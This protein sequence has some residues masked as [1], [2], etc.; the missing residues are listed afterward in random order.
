[1]L[2]L[3]KLSQTLF[4]SLPK[5]V[6]DSQAHI[7][8]VFRDI[9]EKTLKNLHIVTREEFDIQTKVL[10]RTRQKLDHLEKLLEEQIK[11]KD[12]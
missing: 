12:A 6:Q 9:L 3:S 2:D 8:A 7:E 10:A 4:S 5:S 1:M 11:S